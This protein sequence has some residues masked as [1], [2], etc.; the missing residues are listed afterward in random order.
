MKKVISQEET[1]RKILI[2]A[3]QL[4]DE[5]TDKHAVSYEAYKNLRKDAKNGKP[6]LCT[7]DEYEEMADAEKL[8]KIGYENISIQILHLL[9]AV[10]RVKK[11]SKISKE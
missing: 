8:Q 2:S 4:A 11:D 9:Q 5:I 6:R 7:E 10:D 1:L 3:M